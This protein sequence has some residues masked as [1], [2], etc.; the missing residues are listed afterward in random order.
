M[1]ETQKTQCQGLTCLMRWGDKERRIRLNGTETVMAED[2]QELFQ[3]PITDS[4][5]LLSP[6]YN[7]KNGILIHSS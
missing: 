4:R 1:C 7:L 5:N 3:T 6:K 2:F